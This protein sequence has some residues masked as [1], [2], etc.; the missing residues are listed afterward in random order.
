[1]KVVAALLVALAPGL[2]RAGACCAS[3]GAPGFERLATWEDFAFGVRSG[4]SS[5][6][7][8]WDDRGRWAADRDY[9]EQV[10]RTEVYGLAR[11]LGWASVE[12]HVPF[13]RTSRQAGDL[14]GADFGVGDVQVGLRA[15]LV[16]VGESSLPGVALT[17]GLVA[18]TGRASD[19]AQTALGTDVTGR[20]LWIP[21]VGVSLEKPWMP[22]F[23]RLDAAVSAP[24]PAKR[25][26]H[27]R[28]ESP[29]VSG[30]LVLGR[31][32]GKW[33][34]ASASAR[35]QWAGDQRL[36]GRALPDSAARESALGAGLTWH[37]RPG[38][39]AQAA[40]EVPL[41]VDGMGSN[42]NLGLTATLGLRYGGA[43]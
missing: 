35:V 8:G 22:W 40:A 2:A 23:A 12:A 5:S 33:F 25:G 26:G 21:S 16:E 30:A 32:L 20:G 1:V 29:G 17:L 38:L 31:E 37:L 43:W 42:R 4:L 11:V 10:W 24:L 9:D 6:L 41:P 28:G 39:A 3:A 34:T 7:G 15:A 18:P 27:D 19:E 14:S 13:L 36:D